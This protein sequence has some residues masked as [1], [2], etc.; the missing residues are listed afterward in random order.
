M[1]KCQQ[2]SEM[3][4]NKGLPMMETDRKGRWIMKPNKG[5]RVDEGTQA[6]DSVGDEQIE[7]VREGK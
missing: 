3:I 6:E 7:W 1:L 4:S 5:D 2:S